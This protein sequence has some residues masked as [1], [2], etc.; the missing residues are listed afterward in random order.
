MTHQ[1]KASVTGQ[2]EIH[3]IYREVWA[4]QIDNAGDPCPVCQME[5]AVIDCNVYVPEMHHA[6]EL[7]SSC[8]CCAPSV[9]LN[10]PH[11]D[12]CYD[13][14]IEHGTEPRP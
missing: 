8:R 2:P 3:I 7:L 11:L 14:V 13:A 9:I 5:G 1:I 12:S 6:L 10:H 4:D